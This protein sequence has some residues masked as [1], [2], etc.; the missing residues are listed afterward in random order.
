MRSATCDVTLHFWS[1]RRSSIG[2][3][4]SG[5]KTW[6]SRAGQKETGRV[7]GGGARSRIGLTGKRPEF[8]RGAHPTIRT[9]RKGHTCEMY[10]H[11]T[12]LSSGKSAAFQCPRYP[13]PD[14]VQVGKICFA[15]RGGYPRQ[16][17]RYPAPDNIRVAKIC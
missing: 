3:T 9:Q 16:C 2:S 14:N 13:T 7:G 5:S 1:R 15:G 11:G 8:G 12:R 6:P 10:A 4:R 17:P